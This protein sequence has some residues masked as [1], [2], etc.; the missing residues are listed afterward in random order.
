MGVFL[1]L[2]VLDRTRWSDIVAIH[3]W[4]LFGAHSWIVHRYKQEG[5]K[6]LVTSL[7]I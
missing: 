7:E 2:V 6:P 5:T 3:A 1:V 4:G